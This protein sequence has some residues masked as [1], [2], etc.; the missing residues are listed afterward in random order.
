[1]IPIDFAKAI[2]HTVEDFFPPEV[3]IP[4]QLLYKTTWWFFQI[5]NLQ[6]LYEQHPHSNQHFF[7]AGAIMAAAEVFSSV[8][9]VLRLVLI[10]KGLQ[11]ICDTQQRIS[12]LGKRFVRLFHEPLTEE[13]PYRGERTYWEGDLLSPSQSKNLQRVLWRVETI[14]KLGIDILLELGKQL[15]TLVVQYDTVLAFCTGEEQ[16]IP[17]F[18]QTVELINLKDQYLDKLEIYGNELGRLFRKTQNLIE[19]FLINQN[20][21]AKF[22]KEKSNAI[23]EKFET[24]LQVTD[25]VTTKVHEGWQQ[26]NSMATSLES[27]A[28]SL[29]RTTGSN[30]KKSISWIAADPKKSKQTVTPSQSFPSGKSPGK[31]NLF[32]PNEALR[33]SPYPYFLGQ[34]T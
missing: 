21:D 22:V 30:L 29:Q 23:G 32:A 17:K 1:M 13:Y 31:G 2:S 33:F 19:Q 3:T 24:V 5:S 4:T 7:A 27:P 11:D 15:A 26:A 9:M 10:G 14:W 16:Q 28:S 25:T 8:D 18:V 12:D 6:K 34:V 20:W